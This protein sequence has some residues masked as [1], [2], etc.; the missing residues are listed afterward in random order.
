MPLNLGATT[1]SR[2][3]S[4][5]PPRFEDDEID[6]MIITPPPT[7]STIPTDTETDA[8]FITPP[9]TPNTIPADAET[10]DTITASPLA[11]NT[12]P[13]D[14]ENDDTTSAPGPTPDTSSRTTGK[15]TQ[16]L[17]VF[18][19]QTRSLQIPKPMTQML[20]LLHHRPSSIARFQQPQGSLNDR[21]LLF[22]GSRGNTNNH[23]TWSYFVSK[24]SSR[25]GAREESS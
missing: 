20:R 22:R 15:L 5:D 2:A 18:Q 23:S 6:D 25:F 12:I 17:L 13:E 11:P 4:T 21:I 19:Y 9:Q 1:D 24:L 8:T 3:P 10:N 14:T 16:L 7:P